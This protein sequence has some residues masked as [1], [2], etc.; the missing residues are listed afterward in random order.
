MQPLPHSSPWDVIPASGGPYVDT[1]ERGMAEMN[2]FR[3]E[4]WQRGRTR[5]FSLI[6]VLCD[7]K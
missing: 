2:T 3:Q 5:L 1:A 6:A 4:R 7:S